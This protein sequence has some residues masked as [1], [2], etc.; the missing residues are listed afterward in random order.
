MISG[1]TV[2]MLQCTPLASTAVWGKK[3]KHNHC[4]WIPVDLKEII[5]FLI[6][7]SAHWLRFLRAHFTVNWILLC[8]KRLVSITEF[9][10]LRSSIQSLLKN[11]GGRRFS[12]LYASISTFYSIL[13]RTLT[14]STIIKTSHRASNSLTVSN[15]WLSIK[16]LHMLI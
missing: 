5:F 2:N 3:L 4:Q 7:F 11:I 10:N 6:I 14:F 8:S 1:I 9:D 13:S 15:M 16:Y 12:F